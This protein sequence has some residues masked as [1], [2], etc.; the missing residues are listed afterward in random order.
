[1]PKKP[2]SK[3][4]EIKISTVVAV[5]A[6][7]H[8]AEPA[9]LQAALHQ[10][11][12]GVADFF[13]HEFTVIDV[14][15]LPEQARAALDW[16]ALIGAAALG[17]PESGRGAQRHAGDGSGDRRPRPLARQRTAAACRSAG[18]RRPACATTAAGSARPRRRQPGRDD[19]HRYPGTRRPA[20]LCARRPDRHRRRQQRRRNHRRRQHP[21]LRAAARARAGRRQRQRRSAHLR[22]R[23]GSGTGVDRRR[24]PHFRKRF[25]ERTGA[26][27]GPDSPAR[28]PARSRQ[29]PSPSP[30]RNFNFPEGAFLWQKSS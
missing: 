12:G 24:L 5:C 15:A 26:K 20:R 11:T 17:A 22:V 28:R 10:M 13:D 19:D 16:E 29:R 2:S 6:I 18:A 7:L 3:P 23:H 8:E 21:R 4:I 27:A 9:A 30:R 14:G 25:S 1:M